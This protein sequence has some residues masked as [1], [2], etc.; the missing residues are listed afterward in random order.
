MPRCPVCDAPRVTIV[1]GK[2]R[3]G[4]CSACGARWIQDGD[5]QRHVEPSVSFTQRT[6]AR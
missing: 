3:R 4:L 1:L 2:T 5:M 6:G